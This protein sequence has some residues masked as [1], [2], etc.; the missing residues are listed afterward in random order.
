MASSFRDIDHVFTGDSSL[1][2]QENDNFSGVPSARAYRKTMINI[3][4][5]FLKT[6][7]DK[8]IFLKAYNQVKNTLISIN[9]W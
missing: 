5:N 3:N 8:N 6:T 1:S 4:I 2:E 9:F 7:H